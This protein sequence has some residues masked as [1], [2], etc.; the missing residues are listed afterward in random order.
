MVHLLKILDR[1]TICLQSIHHLTSDFLAECSYSNLDNL[2]EFQRKRQNLFNTIY[3]LDEDLRVQLSNES[4]S[5]ERTNIKE[6]LLLQGRLIKSIIAL[7]EALLTAID[8]IK[9]ET[10]DKL[11]SLSQQKRILSGYKSSTERIEAA[12]G[13]GYLDKKL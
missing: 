10:I 3:K 11:H 6:A 9:S 5:I 8:A 13:S 1:K 2:M 7:D 12:E 4:D